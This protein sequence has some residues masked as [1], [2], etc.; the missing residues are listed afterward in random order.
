MQ[1]FTISDSGELEEVKN[2]G[3]IK[4]Y[5]KSDKVIVVVD[6]EKRRI[7]I[8]KGSKASIRQKF[9]SARAATQIRQERGLSYK[10]NSVDEGEE[11]EEFS[12]IAGIPFTP[13]PPPRPVVR[14][15]RLEKVSLVQPPPKKP[16]EKPAPPKPVKEVAPISKPVGVNMLR[17]EKRTYKSSELLNIWEKLKKIDLPAGFRR[18]LVIIG[19]TAYAVTE[20]KVSFLGKEKIDTRLEKVSTLPE[21]IFLADKYTPRVII[22]NGKVIAVELLKQEKALRIPTKY[23][24]SLKDE[25]EKD[26]KDLIDFFK[27]EVDKKSSKK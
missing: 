3:S 8:W 20:Y 5:L 4:D 12:K 24:P 1:L 25:M 13:S 19:D 18:E 2:G 17:V 14:E 23:K 27:I 7:W 11:N 26:L 22:D 9:I 6:D 21:G 10:V 15:A 16:V